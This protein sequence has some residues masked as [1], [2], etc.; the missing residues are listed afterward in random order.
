LCKLFGQLS[1]DLCQAKGN[2]N[3]T[4]QAWSLPIPL[5]SD[6]GKVPIISNKDTLPRDP[7]SLPYSLMASL[8]DY[9][10]RLSGCGL[11]P[12]RTE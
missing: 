11:Q 2:T 6:L 8:N 10:D 12:S 7:F 4:H 5:I 3:T 1:C 9:A